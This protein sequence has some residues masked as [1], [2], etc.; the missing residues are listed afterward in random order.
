MARH[1]GTCDCHQCD[2]KLVIEAVDDGG[3]FVSFEKP[4]RALPPKAVDTHEIAQ[5]ERERE[6]ARKARQERMELIQLADQA[7]VLEEA[8]KDAAGLQGVGKTL[9]LFMA[10]SIIAILAGVFAL[11]QTVLIIGG[12]GMAIT[13]IGIGGWSQESSKANKR[14]TDHKLKYS[15]M[16]RRMGIDD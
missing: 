15:R 4:R 3:R 16:Q 5:R 13:G 9:L 7:D 12:I 14:Y 1:P 11:G 2:E 6:A 8:R 10:L